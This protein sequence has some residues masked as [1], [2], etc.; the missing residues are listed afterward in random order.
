MAAL[1]LLTG[2]IRLL[3]RWQ[4]F[5]HPDTAHQLLVC[6]LMNAAMHEF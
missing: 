3:P 6:T 4:G 1:V 5:A 2:D